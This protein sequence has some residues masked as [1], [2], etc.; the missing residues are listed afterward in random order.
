MSK[1]DGHIAVFSRV[2]DLQF[3]VVVACRQRMSGL[4]KTNVNDALTT[5]HILK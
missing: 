1:S 5:S 2:N 4:G 3:K